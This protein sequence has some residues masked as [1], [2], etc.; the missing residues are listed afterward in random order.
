M[1]LDEL[2]Q[3]FKAKK[4]VPLY[5]FRGTEN[6]L[7]QEAIKELRKAA[8]DES[9]WMF[10]WKEYSVASQGLRAV[11]TTASEYPMFGERQVIIARDFE[12]TSDEELDLLKDYLKNPL[13]T[14]ILVFQAQELDKR[15]SFS[16]ALLKTCMVVDLN[17]LKEREAID[18]VINYLSRN[19]YQITGAT[20][21][22]L[23]SL[24]GTDLFTLRN[25]LE[26]LMANLGRSAMISP[27]DVENLVTP[28]KEHSNFELA[29]A[30]LARETKT[31]MRL[32]TRQLSNN[33]DPILLLAVVARVF[34]QMLIAKDLMQQKVSADEI[35]KEAGIP[36]FRITDFLT[37]VRR[38]DTNKIVFAVK[39]I[40]E[41]DNAMKNSLGK[42]S[43]QLEYF[44]SEVLLN[45]A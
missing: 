23:V 7:H 42:P 17:P 6:F 39:K 22:L 44:L 8:L 21:G 38:W 2:L 28:V 40:S 18:W 30:I 34:R 33:N 25:E 37:H 12:K 27:Q 43:L 24:T 4:I 26:K 19:K 9:A 13:P 31:T 10:N 29:D 41:V 35:A 16:T 5:L 15:R 20:A 3:Q 1:T 45:T 32:L 36:P 14:T 11:I